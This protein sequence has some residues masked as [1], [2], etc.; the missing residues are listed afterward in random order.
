MMDGAKASQTVQKAS[1]CALTSMVPNTTK[2]VHGIGLVKSARPGPEAGGVKL[3][4]LTHSKRTFG[5]QD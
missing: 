3:P 5:R 4:T 1:A 2:G